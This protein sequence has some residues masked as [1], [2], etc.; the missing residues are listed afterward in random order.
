[1][2]I[3][4]IWLAIVLMPAT[5]YAQNVRTYIPKNAHALLPLLKTEQER[6][7]P[8]F[9][10]PEYFGGLI[11]HESCISLTH[12]R[13]WNP[14]SR[15][16]TS[17][18]EG[19]GLGQVTRAYDAKGKLRFDT[20][21]DLKRKYRSEL[22]E[23]SWANVY[24]RPDLQIRGVLLLSKENYS[25]FSGASNTYERTAMADAAYN[26]GAGSV[27]KSR[28]SCNLAKG[29][30][31]SKWFNNTE[32]YC[33]KSKKPLYGNRSACDIWLNHPKD[34]MK[35]RMNKYKPYLRTELGAKNDLTSLSK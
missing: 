12:S 10:Q 24:D 26:G 17:R 5:T 30:D 19:A 15:L 23:W 22:G 18:E 28:Q 1:M 34:V 13:C 8:G 32:R 20:L 4:Y 11:E 3:F 25:R 27:Q 16:K 14:K 31:A 7:F 9:E 29:C 2:R 35:V 33:H 21:A 6:I